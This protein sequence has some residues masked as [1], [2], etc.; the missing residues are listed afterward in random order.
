LRLGLSATLTVGLDPFVLGEGSLDLDDDRIRPSL[1]LRLVIIPRIGVR[2]DERSLICEMG[3]DLL[4]RWS[5]VDIDASVGCIVLEA[6]FEVACQQSASS[7]SGEG[8]PVEPIQTQ[9]MT[10]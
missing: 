4:G 1:V 5:A 8:Q 7:S 9:R 3:F 10:C 2:R 6:V